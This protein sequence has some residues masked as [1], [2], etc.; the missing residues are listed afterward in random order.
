MLL[1]FVVVWLIDGGFE[2]FFC[3]FDWLILPDYYDINFL[4]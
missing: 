1:F 3:L 4:I 2:G